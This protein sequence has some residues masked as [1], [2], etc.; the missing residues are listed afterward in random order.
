VHRRSVRAHAGQAFS[1]PIWGGARGAADRGSGSATQYSVKGSGPA[2]RLGVPADDAGMSRTQPG[3]AAS[4]VIPAHNEERTLPSTLRALLAG[5]P[6]GV[7][8]VVVVCNGCTDDTAAVARSVPGVR[9]IEIPEAS[10]TRAV[11]V[12]NHATDV[13]PRIH[14]DADVTLR[15]CD[16]LRLL[17]ALEEDGVEAVAP[18]RWVPVDRS[19]WPVRAYYRVWQS[20]PQVREGLFGRGVLV[21]SSAGQARVD[22]LPHL[23][24][25]DL[26]VS[27]AFLPR[28]RRVVPDA[29]AVVHPPRT[30]AAL[31]RRRTRIVTGNAQYDEAGVG[32]TSTSIG[33]LLRLGRRD[34]QLLLCLPVFGGIA[35]RARW[36]A[37]RAIRSADFTTWLR[38]ESS[39]A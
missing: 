9:V 3:V 15:G 11:E 25:D 19:S 8:D 39:R 12:G 10:K 13:F 33:T 18:H 38:D 16:A 30:V 22:E 17:E 28:E 37:R 27:E 24:N 7:F 29:F 2:G 32:R 34:P 26:A 6:E 4:V 21:L 20:L 14:L 35:L 31:V 1:P 36:G 23:M 5:V